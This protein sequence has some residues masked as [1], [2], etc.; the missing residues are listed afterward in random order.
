M[1]I[2]HRICAALLVMPLFLSTNSRAEERVSAPETTQAEA[3][4]QKMSVAEVKAAIDGGIEI[5]IYD[6]NSQ[7]S[8]LAGH[9]PSAKWVEYDTVAASALPASKNAKLVFYCYNPLCTASPLAARRARELGY[10]NVWTMPAGITGWRD[11]GMPV[12]AGDHAN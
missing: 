11:A 9:V 6:A 2:A 3:A 8:Y 4:A 1:Q 5:H 10:T 7:K 12:V